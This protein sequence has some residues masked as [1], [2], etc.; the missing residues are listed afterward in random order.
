[1][2]DFERRLASRLSAYEQSVSVPDPLSVNPA[3]HRRAWAAV[4]V[5]VVLAVGIG[6]VGSRL[7]SGVRPVGNGPVTSLTWTTRP[8]VEGA[9]VVDLRPVGTRLIAT[10]GMAA[11]DG[12]SPDEPAAWYSDDGGVTWAASSVEDHS[13]GPAGAPHW[14]ARV[15]EHD[16]RLLALDAYTFGQASD[17]SSGGSTQADVST[18][19]WSS[20]D[21]GRSWTL[22]TPVPG[23]VSAIAAGPE[24]IIALGTGEG[25]VAVGWQSSDGTSWQ[26][27]PL[28][29]MAE[30]AHVTDVAY[31]GSGFVAVG[32][33]SAQDGDTPDARAPAAWRSA[34]G[35][36]WT[37]TQLAPMGSA[38][39]VYA[40]SSSIVAAG[41]ISAGGQELSGTAV[42][43]RPSGAAWTTQSLPPSSPSGAATATGIVANDLG[44][45]A[46]V[47]RN[48]G[49]GLQIGQEL[50]FTPTT[51]GSEPKEQGLDIQVSALASLPDRFVVISN[52]GKTLSPC[53][54]S[55]S[56]G[57]GVRSPSSS[58]SPS[59]SSSS[60]PTPAIPTPSSDVHPSPSAATAAWIATPIGPAGG[61]Q[62]MVE[63]GPT[64]TAFGWAQNE[65]GTPGGETVWTSG[66][67]LTWSRVGQIDVG[68]EPAR[69]V[70]LTSAV[71]LGSTYVV[72]GYG[73]VDQTLPIILT[74][75]DR[76]DWALARLPKD[77]TCGRLDTLI[78]QG[79]RLIA[80]GFDCTTH[81]ALFLTSAD[82]DAWT[83]D[84]L[85]FA[86]LDG[87]EVSGLID[88]NGDLIAIGSAIGPDSLPS[89][90]V[91]RSSAGKG[92][93]IG[94]LGK[95]H[96]RDIVALGD[97][98]VVVGDV[99]GD[100]VTTPAIWISNDG[101]NW[102]LARLSD[103]ANGTLASVLSVDGGFVA[104]GTEQRADGLQAPMLYTSPDGTHWERAEIAGFGR[105]YLTGALATRF[106]PIAFGTSEDETGTPTPLVVTSNR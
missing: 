26:P 99:G 2:D 5:V 89:A 56:I 25:G 21:H 67:G 34:D 77:L 39:A 54:P 7:L 10:G 97:G 85:G 98:L 102:S 79:P 11:A 61:I 63:S 105:G 30:Q 60:A 6:L 23:S 13:G 92:E 83:R 12:S 66:D 86:D 59:T 64:L 48:G 87:A 47:Q 24:R 38:N 91:W 76:M 49:R 37:V 53:A 4:A 45:L 15:V 3:P 33:V 42:I 101:I 31:D 55:V 62:A 9:R 36:T 19:V 1:M 104:I 72:G 100:T 70:G 68:G 81:R 96:A 75:D 50:W 14:L 52:C 16:G 29:G 22:A 57:T 71:W 40:D 93:A 32:S 58:P 103:R 41:G 74:S 44:A 82:G 51:E 17:L 78:E 35:Q 46:R 80:A 27:L 20:D 90:R 43:W 18:A 65:A 84:D 69:E 73:G 28:G 8:F 94:T 95:G 106:G 88:A